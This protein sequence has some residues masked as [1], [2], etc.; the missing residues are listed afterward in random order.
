M[1]YKGMQL[2]AMLAAMLILSMAFVP[3]VSAQGAQRL[4]DVS[5]GINSANVQ[6]GIE[7]HFAEDSRGGEGILKNKKMAID[8]ENVY[9]KLEIDIPESGEYYVTAWVMGVNGQEK[10]QVY[11]DDEANPAGYLKISDNGWQSA[12][13]Q[14]KNTFNPISLFKGTHVFSFKSQDIPEIEFIRVAKQKDA[15]IISDTNYRNYINTLKAKSLPDNYR[16]LKNEDIVNAAMVLT[17]NPEGDYAYQLNMNFAYTYYRAF[18]FTSGQN[19][20]FETRKSDP[21]A[22]DPVMFL[23]SGSDPVNGGS[24]SNDDWGNGYQSK[25]SVTIPNTGTYYLL[26]RSYSSSYP[27]T[28]DL[29]KD[30]SL[31]ASNVAL[32]GTNVYNGDI[33][34]TGTLNYFT[35]KLTGDSRLWLEDSSSWP[36]KIKGFNDDYSGSGDFYW[37]VASR[38]KQQFSPSINYALVSSYSSSNPTGT[39]DLYMKLDNSDIT[40]FFPNLKADD[41][42]KSA[43]AS[44]AYNCISWSGGRVDLGRYF[45]PPDPGN[46]W[47]DPNQL[48]A[49]D[50]FYGNNPSRYSGAMTY[51]RTGATVDNSV[52]DLWAVNGVYT[53]ASVKKP[54]NDQPHGYDWE[55]KPG[56]LMRTL[57]P[58]YAL[59][60]DD[61]GD[62][63]NYYKQTGTYASGV[64]SQAIGGMTLEESIESGLTV[65]EKVELTE[66]EK[67]KQSNLIENI[68]KEVNNEFNTKYGLWKETWNDPNLL[69]HSNPRMYAQ[70]KQYKDFLSY[71]KKHGKAIWPL[72]FQK[73][74]QGDDFVK[75]AILD[76][77][78]TEHGSL[79]DEIRQESAKERYTAEGVYIAPSENANMM[80]YIKKLLEL[81]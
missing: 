71:S 20:V 1:K 38:V 19:V 60:G 44:D 9:T 40:S 69:I 64:S 80:K 18:Y 68:P 26:L 25:I 72:L 48:T 61:Y 8:G 66:D 12:Q 52:V 78:Y 29:Y 63:S 4:E 75:M 43:P 55:S 34:K 37:G 39:A 6:A 46:P 59:R 11:L 23:F 49:F 14:D 36:G 76:L 57:H 47:Y 41:A 27:G 15:A 3:A 65:I 67:A 2:G 33:S 45:W 70:S 24:W 62:V 56:G 32:A 30:G 28:S 22:S 73:Y 21:Y 51:T 5:K 17:S 31:Y 42:I 35:A 53:H 74:E 7:K 77:T 16:Q 81:K 58:R 79:L 10:I 13:L 50:K 54:G